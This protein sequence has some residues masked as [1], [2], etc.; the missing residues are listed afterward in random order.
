M[1]LLRYLISIVIAAIFLL[2][3]CKKEDNKPPMIPDNNTYKKESQ[4]TGIKI[5]KYSEAS[6]SRN[7]KS[8]IHV[9]HFPHLPVPK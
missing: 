2:T 9:T 4:K 5:E 8:G 1:Y 6:V 7:L 3:S